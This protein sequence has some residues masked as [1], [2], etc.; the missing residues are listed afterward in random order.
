MGIP[1]RRS[2]MRPLRRSLIVN[3]HLRTPTY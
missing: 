1:Q 2:E 3:F